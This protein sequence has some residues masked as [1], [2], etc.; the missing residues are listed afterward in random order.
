MGDHIFRVISGFPGSYHHGIYISEK[1]IVEFVRET[2]C[3]RSLQEFAEKKPLYR[4][5]YRGFSL[6]ANETKILAMDVKKY[7]R[8]YCL[9][10]CNCEHFATFLKV[11]I[12][13]SGQVCTPNLH[14]Q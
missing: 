9:F 3:V 1:M 14:V 12:N 5:D 10:T 7:P 4:R 11:K 13:W 8:E 2:V 6:S